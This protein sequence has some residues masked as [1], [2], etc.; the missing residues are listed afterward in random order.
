MS[1]VA[2]V[3]T[4]ARDPDFGSGYQSRAEDFVREAV[5]LLYRS[6]V[7]ARGV[8]S[9]TAQTAAGSTLV[10]SASLTAV[11]AGRVSGV[12]HQDNGDELDE[13]SIE[14]WGVLIARHLAQGRPLVYAIATGGVTGEAPSLVVWPTANAVYNLLVS[15]DN[16]PKASELEVG[17]EVPLPTDYQRLAEYYARRELYSKFEGDF[18]MSDDWD[19]R[20]KEGQ[21][22]MRADLQRRSKKNRVVP[23]TWSRSR[24][25]A[26]VLHHPSGLF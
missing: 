1:T 14:D 9:V 11:V 24:A 26:P 15:G 2:Q 16:A 19:K 12:M 20:W 23:G 13:V 18:P 17:D 25:V 3:A 10:A 5:G 4:N 21:A 7:I 8:M 6:A 22:E